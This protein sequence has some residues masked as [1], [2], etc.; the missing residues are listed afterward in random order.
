M[1]RQVFSPEDLPSKWARLGCVLPCLLSH[2][3]QNDLFLNWT[4]RLHSTA[5]DSHDT[6]NVQP[7]QTR[8]G[9]TE[10]N[11]VSTAHPRKRRRRPPAE[12]ESRA[13]RS[14]L[15]AAAP[16]AVPRSSDL[17]QS[18]AQI[19]AAE[20]PPW[21]GSPTALLHRSKQSPGNSATAFG[22]KPAIGQASPGIAEAANTQRSRAA[23]PVQN[24]RKAESALGPSPRSSDRS[25][26]RTDPER[27][28]RMPTP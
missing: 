10:A 7:P 8:A 18:T 15:R 21:S 20:G 12:R 6:P 16:C 9:R 13:S 28:A 3:K 26:K 25:A 11:D 1:R 19:L 22:S 24:C 5:S 4:G 17:N 2:T 27:P 23:G 14:A